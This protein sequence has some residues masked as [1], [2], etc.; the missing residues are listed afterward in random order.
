M[1]H[2]YG[3]ILVTSMNNTNENVFIFNG[4]FWRL[5]FEQSHIGDNIFKVLIMIF[6][7]KG[8][9]RCLIWIISFSL[10]NY[11]RI[12]FYY[13]LDFKDETKSSVRLN[14][15]SSYWV[16]NDRARI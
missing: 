6:C 5:L 14:N 10:C 9:V 11:M 1:C 4:Q 12:R 8:Y 2:H 13:Y 7:V 3:L 15:M 16:R